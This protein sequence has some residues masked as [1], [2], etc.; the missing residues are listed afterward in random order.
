MLDIV[1]YY[2]RNQKLYTGWLSALVWR[3]LMAAAR[4][5]WLWV[6]LKEGL[7]TKEEA[8]LNGAL[9][10]SSVWTELL[11]PLSI[12][13]RKKTQTFAKGFACKVA[14]GAAGQM[15]FQLGRCSGMG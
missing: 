2:S 11:T 13:R 3:T 12:L 10:P 14:G 6:V 9:K 8:V 5:V 15:C 4:S 1:I 7:I